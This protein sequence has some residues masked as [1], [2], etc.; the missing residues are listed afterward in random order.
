MIYKKEQN[1]E[2]LARYAAEQEGTLQTRDGL[3]EYRLSYLP[4]LALHGEREIL[5]REIRDGAP[6]LGLDMDILWIMKEPMYLRKGADIWQGNCF[7]GIGWQ[8]YTT[9]DAAVYGGQYETLQMLLA[10]GARF[11]LRSKRLREMYYHCPDERIL[12]LAFE[13]KEYHAEVLEIDR[14]LQEPL[15]SLPFPPFTQFLSDGFLLIPA[16][17]DLPIQAV[18]QLIPLQCQKIPGIFV[19]IHHGEIVLHLLLHTE[20]IPDKCDTVGQHSVPLIHLFFHN[21]ILLLSLLP[22]FYKFLRLG[23]EPF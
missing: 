10:K 21:S 11:D 15:L 23:I 7:S 22:D 20:C 14:I 16:L 5:E 4:E 1:K 13:K 2:S 6:R 9:L 17:I 3:L 18:K 8:F 12:R 19:S